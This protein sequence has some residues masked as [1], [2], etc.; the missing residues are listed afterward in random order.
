[1]THV[2][3]KEYPLF[4]RTLWRFIECAVLLLTDFWRTHITG[5]K[6]CKEGKLSVQEEAPRPFGQSETSPLARLMGRLS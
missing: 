1:M 3:V 5:L 6:M 2:Q 4:L